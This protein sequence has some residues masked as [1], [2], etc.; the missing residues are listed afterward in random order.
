MM[1]T[2]A[3]LCCLTPRLLLA[4]LLLVFVTPMHAVEGRVP[5]FEPVTLTNP[6]G[7]YILTRNISATTPGSVLT[8][9]GSGQESVDLDLNGFTVTGSGGGA[10][11][12][13]SGLKSLTI[14]NG[15]I[16][17]STASDAVTTF[18]DLLII[19]D[20][21]VEAVAQGIVANDVVQF[22]ARRNTIRDVA[23]TAIAFQGTPGETAVGTVEDNVIEDT[24]YIAIFA[25]NDITAVTISGNKLRNTGASTFGSIQTQASGPVE[26]VG[27]T[28]EDAVGVGI[29][30]FAEGCI[31]E[32][33]V[34]E[35]SA[36]QGIAVTSFTDR[37]SCIVRSNVVSAS[38]DEGL[39]L[40]ADAVLVQENVL[41]ANGDYGLAFFGADNC[42]YLN[43]TIVGNVAG[44]IND[45]GVGNIALGP[46]HCF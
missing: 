7:Q 13:A 6:T 1:R 10:V 16:N 34:V 41:N 44:C 18:V 30:V 12:Y 28:V 40:W 42:G 5:I 8:L 3:T 29:S 22:V 20:T 27:N 33:N 4:C 26:I 2:G 43:N 15:T 45:L 46:N 25:S 11:I 21:T 39:F 36:E 9:T 32:N 35:G 38:G 19:E 24:G 31:I 14:R 17:G 23:F 37:A